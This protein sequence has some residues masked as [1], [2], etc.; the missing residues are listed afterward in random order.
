M[1]VLESAICLPLQ[2]LH[3]STDLPG[4]R[5]EGG[6]EGGR[7]RGLLFVCYLSAVESF[8][9]ASAPLP[10]FRGI[11]WVV[12]TLKTGVTPQRLCAWTMLRRC[13]GAMC[14]CSRAYRMS[15]DSVARRSNA[16]Q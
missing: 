5:L 6:R 12:L 9:P 7:L 1:Q 16:L 14:L 13:G 8:S 4:V 11:G 3:R 15:L 2:R 10:A